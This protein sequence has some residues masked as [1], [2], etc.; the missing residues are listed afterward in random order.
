L[1]ELI[2]GSE[3]LTSGSNIQESSTTSQDFECIFR[4]FLSIYS[5]LPPESKKRKMQHVVN[6]P[7]SSQFKELLET[8]W[9]ER[10]THQ[11]ENESHCEGGTKI[12]DCVNCPYKMELGRIENF[13]EDIFA[14][15]GP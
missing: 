13:Y 3:T 6:T 1:E 12:C 9:S 14:L 5:S 8:C 7:E 11:S 15:R 4:D 2:E 10:M